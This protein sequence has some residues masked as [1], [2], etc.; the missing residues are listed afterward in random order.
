[1]DKFS[2]LYIIRLDDP[3]D[4]KNNYINNNKKLLNELIQWIK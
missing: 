2:L 4:I 1:M 3:I